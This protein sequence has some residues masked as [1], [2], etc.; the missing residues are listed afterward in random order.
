MQA[1]ERG[2]TSGF[3]DVDVQSQLLGVNVSSSARAFTM[4]VVALEVLVED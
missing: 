3:V 4:D 1:S 2:F